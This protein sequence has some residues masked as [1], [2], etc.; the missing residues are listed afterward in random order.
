MVVQNV[1]RD[2]TEGKEL[3]ATVQFGGCLSTLSI[4]K[5]FWLR[6]AF[7]MLIVLYICLGYVY[8]CLFHVNNV[9]V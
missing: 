5:I 9:L 6:Y 2:C 4:L 1:M 8:L 3:K 7:G